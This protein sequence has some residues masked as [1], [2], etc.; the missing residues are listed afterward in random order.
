MRDR[1]RHAAPHQELA[2]LHGDPGAEGADPLLPGK[3]RQRDLAVADLHDED[4]GL[5]LAALL[6]GW[7]VLLEVDGAVDAGEVHA[8]ERVANRLGVVLPRDFHGLGDRDDAVVTAEALGE[9]FEWIAALGPLVDERLGQ[10]A[11]RHG[12]REPGH[13][14]DDVV[15]PFGS[16]ASLLDEL[17]RRGRAAR[18]DDLSAQALLLGL[19]Q[20]EGD[21]LHR[22]R[23]EERVAAGRLDLGDLRVHVGRAL[24]HEF[25][26]ADR[27]ALLLQEVPERLDRAAAPVRVDGEEVRLLDGE[28]V[29]VGLEADRFHLARRTDPEDPRIAALGDGCGAR[30]LDDHGHAV[31]LELR[32][33]RQRHRAPPGAH[34]GRDLVADDQLLGGARRLLG[35]RL[36]VLDDELDLPPEDPALGVEPVACDLGAHADV[37]SRGGHRPRQRLD[38][39]NPDRRLRACDVE[40]DDDAAHESGNDADGEDREEPTLPHAEASCRAQSLLQGDE[41]IQEREEVVMTAVKSKTYKAQSFD[42]MKGLDGISDA[43]I[44]EHLKLYEGY[45]KQVNALNAELAEL[46]AKGKAAGTNPEFAELTRRLGFE[47]N[48]MI[49]HEYYFENLRPAADPK[50]PASSGLAQAIGSSFESIE[51]WLTDFQAIGEMRGVGW[52]I[53][54]EDPMTNRLSNHWITLHQEGIPAGFKPVLV[55]DVWEHA[56]MRDYKAT[57]RKKYV[58]AFFRNIDWALVER[59]LQ[60]TASVRPA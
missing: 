11:V 18:G 43:Q 50:P 14:E 16:R 30:R 39:A 26:G 27:Q 19:L 29:D 38:D 52:V 21:L 37:V 22:G 32:H 41:I 1:L 55:M 9:A 40:A 23:Q 42:H 33:G 48:G 7:A 56:F 34:D 6:A 3:L 36:V 35:I 31:L 54:F 25:G 49:L 15:R 59:R 58:E 46:R 13:E 10:L 51:Q 57:E 53:L 47:Y 45:V 5:A 4:R 44:A 8:P 24:L 28:L 2:V 12:F 60:Q 17:G 20:D